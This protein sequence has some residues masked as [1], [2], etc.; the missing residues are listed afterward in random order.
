MIHILSKLS[1]R[2]RK[3]G[4]P[5][6]ADEI[7]KIIL[8][9]DKTDEDIADIAANSTGLQENSNHESMRSGITMDPIFFDSGDLYT[10]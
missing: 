3:L 1:I 9:L 4:Y 8:N 6:P 5:E 10:R 2:L 7:E